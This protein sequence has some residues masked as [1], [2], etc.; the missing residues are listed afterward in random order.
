MKS[1]LSHTAQF[2]AQALS[3]TARALTDYPV[4]GVGVLVGGI[5]GVILGRRRSS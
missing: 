5:L 4:I 1:L 2:T 3:V